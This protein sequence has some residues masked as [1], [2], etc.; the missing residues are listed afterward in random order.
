MPFIT[1]VIPAYNHERFIGDALE[2]VL[3]QTIQD[4][5]LIVV[6]DGSTDATALVVQQYR[7][8]RFRLL[9][10]TNSGAPSALNRGINE[11]K[12]KWIA[13]LNSDDRFHA[14]K[15]ER[16]LQAHQSN[17]NIEAS[18]SRVRYIDASGIPKNS[19]SYYTLR[20][21]SM[22][23]KASYAHSLFASLV[24]ENHLIT[25]SCL[26]AKRDALLEVGGFA[27]FRYV[28]DWFMFLSLASRGKF[29]VIEEELSDYRR[30]AGN[31]IKEDD[32]TGQIE[33][34]LALAWQISTYLEQNPADEEVGV[35]F[36][37]LSRNIRVDFE[38]LS[39]LALWRLHNGGQALSS[40]GII[41]A[42]SEWFRR[43]CYQIV[44]R[45]R[46]RGSFRRLLQNVALLKEIW[47]K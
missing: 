20:Y 35:V 36:S 40:K 1:V 9:R 31:T 32:I 33:D 10:Q 2:S 14:N 4:W 41:Q 6:D 17:P 38:L 18:A 45:K 7:D 12:G 15:L 22:I 23:R 27:D 3:F 5:E 29:V 42:Q 11:A 43:H 46:M 44:Q 13:F 21:R 30:H 28:H 26:F 39:L 47:R 16:H 19:Y 37:N 24:L 34:N 25:T 8:S